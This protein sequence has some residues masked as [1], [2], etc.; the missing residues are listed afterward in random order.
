MVVGGGKGFQGSWRGR[1]A[2]NVGG[3]AAAGF[4]FCQVARV[5]RDGNPSL[6]LSCRSQKAA[7]L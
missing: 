5:P 4:S 3:R 1:R 6:R 2:G 7:F